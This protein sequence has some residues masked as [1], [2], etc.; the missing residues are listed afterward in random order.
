MSQ[1]HHDYTD[2]GLK[3]GVDSFGRKIQWAGTEAFGYNLTYGIAAAVQADPNHIT[4]PSQSDQIAALL[5]G[6][7]R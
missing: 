7:R 4:L 1:D 6:D 2:H 3:I 5:M